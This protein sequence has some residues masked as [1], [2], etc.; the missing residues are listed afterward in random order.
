MREIR[1]S[2]YILIG[3]VLGLVVAAAVI[4]E[5]GGVYEY[6][7]IDTGDDPIALVN[8]DGWQPIAEMKPPDRTVALYYRR[9]RL[10]LP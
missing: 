5:T 9:P 8:R 10:R 4:F 2:A 3:F 6:H 1:A 7:V